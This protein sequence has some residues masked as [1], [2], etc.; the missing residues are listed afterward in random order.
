MRNRVSGH[1]KNGV[2]LNEIRGDKSFLC[3][4]PHKR[5]IPR[6]YAEFGAYLIERKL[7]SF[8]GFKDPTYADRLRRST[9]RLG[10]RAYCFW[11]GHFRRGEGERGEE[12]SRA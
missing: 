2:Q 8:E 11:R 5:A 4:H 6:L 3:K 10:C 9:V 7:Y 1:F 12:A